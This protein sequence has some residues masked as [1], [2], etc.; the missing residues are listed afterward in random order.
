MSRL[1]RIALNR[2][3]TEGLLDFQQRVGTRS[4]RRLWQQVQ[5]AL[6]RVEQ[7]QLPIEGT[8][9]WKSDFQDFWV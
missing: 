9:E 8:I 6:A 7:S 1:P 4:I 5:Q 2:K 3:G